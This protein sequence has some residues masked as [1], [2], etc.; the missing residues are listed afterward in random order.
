MR[1]PEIRHPVGSAFPSEQISRHT[2]NLTY[3]VIKYK[4]IFRKGEGYEKDRD[5]WHGLS[6][7][8]SF[9]EKCRKSGKGAWIKMRD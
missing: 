9:S 8:H 5:F 7:M 2:D 1:V 6:K 3:S 4:K